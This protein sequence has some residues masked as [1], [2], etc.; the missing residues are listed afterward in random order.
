MVTGLLTVAK[1]GKAAVTSWVPST[2]GLDGMELDLVNQASSTTVRLRMRLENEIGCCLRRNNRYSKMPQGP[3]CPPASTRTGHGD[4]RVGVRLLDP[5]DPVAAVADV[6]HAGLRAGEGLRLYHAVVGPRLGRAFRSCA[7]AGISFT[8]GIVLWLY[9]GHACPSLRQ[10]RPG[11]AMRVTTRAHGNCWLGTERNAPSAGYRD[12][13]ELHAP[14]SARANLWVAS[15][16]FGPKSVHR[17]DG[18]T[19]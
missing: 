17:P 5:H 10:A 14:G 2:Q 3:S 1:F 9:C 8:V 12:E 18:C 11:Q 7:D 13:I 19:R 16:G 6:I 4:L 15:C